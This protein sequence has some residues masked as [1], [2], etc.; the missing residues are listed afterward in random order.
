MDGYEQKFK[1]LEFIVDGNPPENVKSLLD[2][3]KADSRSDGFRGSRTEN[4]GSNLFSFSDSRPSLLEESTASKEDLD[5]KVGSESE[6]KRSTFVKSDSA[7]PAVANS[8]ETEDSSL[9]NDKAFKKY[10]EAQRNLKRFMQE[11]VNEKSFMRLVFARDMG[12][13]A[14]DYLELGRQRDKL[15]SVEFSELIEKKQGI[16][17]FLCHAWARNTSFGEKVRHDENGICLPSKDGVKIFRIDPNDV[18]SKNMFQNGFGEPFSAVNPD[19]DEPLEITNPG[20]TFRS[21]SVNQENKVLKIGSVGG[22]NV[23]A[24]EP[25]QVKLAGEFGDYVNSQR[26]LKRFMIEGARAGNSDVLKEIPNEF[27]KLAK[28]YKNLK[29]LMD[30]KDTN[31]FNAELRSALLYLNSTC[32]NISVGAKI[33]SENVDKNGICI[34]KNESL[35]PKGLERTG[36]IQVKQFEQAYGGK[37]SSTDNVWREPIV[38]PEVR[39]SPVK[40]VAKP[41][42]PQYRDQRY[43]PYRYPY[44]GRAPSYDPDNNHYP[45]GGVPLGIIQ[46]LIPLIGLIH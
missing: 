27:G 33:A 24:L 11:I 26:S 29:K 5:Q 38:A 13:L 40:V 39:Q 36:K 4:V 35:I 34:S 17:A 15:P 21:A 19:T 14:K 25:I 22:P 28:Q 46:T 18:I 8:L 16:D 20:P 23:L 1:G 10:V 42:F 2:K 44:R 6:V 12:R 30:D 37:I 9:R 7:P 31:Q 3:C 41:T 32:K 45:T 43:Y